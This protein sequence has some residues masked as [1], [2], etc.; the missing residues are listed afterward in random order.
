MGTSDISKRD[1]NF[2]ITE[3]TDFSS[4]I[5]EIPNDLFTIYGGWFDKE[6]GIIRMPVDIAKTVSDIFTWGV[7]CTSCVRITFATDS[8]SIKLICKPYD[9]V[10]MHHMAFIGSSGFTLC[11]YVRAKEVFVGNFYAP[12]EDI[13]SYEVQ[14]NIQTKR[15]MRKYVLYCPLYSGVQGLTVELSK[16]SKIEKFERYGKE[17]PIL[18]YGSS[19]TQGGCASRADNLYQ[20]YVMRKY[21]IDCVNLGVSSGAKGEDTIVN[22]L[23][24]CDCSVFVC[25]YDHN[26][27]DVEHLKRTHLPLYKAFRANEKHK[28]TPIVFMS[29]PDGFRDV[30]G[31]E[32]FAV[33]KQ[34][35]DYAKSNGDNN[36]YLID[37]RKIYPKAIAEQCSVDGCHP[38]DLGFYYMFKALD[39]VLS[40]IL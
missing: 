39:K 34:T 26:A 37:G 33:I 15:K 25:D 13:D 6:Y 24:N 12:R 16:G 17:K 40:K 27:P 32:R 5:Y 30:N 31:D 4:D 28:N 38:T 21:N 9:K 36:V 23:A 18:Y 35:Y 22:Y 2:K 20:A 14:L 29:K 10:P 11:E 7:R 1:K 8:D 19:I 3:T